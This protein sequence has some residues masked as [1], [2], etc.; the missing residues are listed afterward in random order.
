MKEM[1]ARKAD[2]QVIFYSDA[3]HAFTQ[4]NVGTDKSK[5]VAYN[6]A[7]ERRSWAALGDFLEE[8]TGK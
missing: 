4:K 8:L 3:V 7:A 5:G 2:F 1:D 6:E